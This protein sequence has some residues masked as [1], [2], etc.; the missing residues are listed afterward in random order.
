MHGVRESVQ[1]AD[2]HR[3]DAKS[4]AR[5]RRFRDARLVEGLQHFATGAD[6][7]ANFEHPRCRNRAFRLHPRVEVG[8]TGNVLPTDFEHVAKSRRGHERGP[9]ALVLQDHVRSDRRAVQHATDLASIRA[10]IGECEAHAGHER[11]RRIG[12]HARRLRTPRP[13]RYGVEQRDVGE[14]PADVDGNG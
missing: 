2:R 4:S 7:L 5:I 3:L 8:A 1:E 10:R 6:T 11:L 14:G 9:R 12:R 13:S